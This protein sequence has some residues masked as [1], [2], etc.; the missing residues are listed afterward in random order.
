MSKKMDASRDPAP[1]WADNDEIDLAEY[2]GLL[3]AGKWTVVAST[4]LI[5]LLGV[6][7][8]LLA[9]PIYQTDLLVQVEEESMG[10][11]GGLDEFSGMFGTETASVTEI[12]VLR[13]RHVVGRAVDQL[14]LTTSVSYSSPPFLGWMNPGR[15]LSEAINVGRLDVPQALEGKAYQILA[16]DGG[17][18]F[19]YDGLVVGSGKVGEQLDIS[20]PEGW[21]K[22]FISRLSA[23]AGTKFALVKKPW[24]MAVADLQDH[25][26]IAEKG[27]STGIIRIS[28]EGSDR[29]SLT[30]TLQVVGDIYVRQNVERKSAEA[31]QSLGFLDAQLPQ[32]R[33]QLDAAEISLNNYLKANQTVNLSAETEAILNR[34]VEIEKQES[35]FNLKRTEL[36]QL[37]GK[38]HPSMVVLSEQKGELKKVREELEAQI[39]QLPA[40]QQDILRLSRD[41]EVNGAL[42][43]FLLNKAQELRVIK[44][45]TVGN[46]R[47]LD[48]PVQ[49]YAPIK[50]KK[51]LIVAVAV[52]LGGFLGV[53]IILLRQALRRGIS[54]PNELEQKLGL[55]L[56]CVVPFSDDEA[57]FN[58][59]SNGKHSRV[60]ARENSKELAIEALRG[61]RTSLHFA[62]MESDNNRVVISGASPGVGKSFL[63]V[64]LAYLLA[65]AGKKVLLIDAD[66]RKGHINQYI[67]AKRSPGLSEVISG[68]TAI[69]NAVHT[70]FE[71]QLSVITTGEYPP[72][73]SELL[74][75]DRFPQLLEQLGND[76][77]VVIIDTPP[78]M[79]VADAGIISPLVGATFVAVRAEVNT[80]DEVDAA[81]KRLSQ[82]GNKVS[83]YLFNGLRRSDSKYGYGKYS[84]YQYEYK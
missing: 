58:R 72:N 21:V 14:K 47:I 82:H 48:N 3:W 49:P 78:I 4:M 20:F 29:A 51:S 67:G 26:S 2:I 17:F 22:V 61:M 54:D 53:A 76:Y 52:L 41:V 44:A 25:L 9:T 57:K 73:P 35:A 56:Y 43:T 33:T 84:Y 66:M 46:V 70:P 77:D 71:V 65:E 28:L 55:P 42:Y 36:E 60:L 24:A 40:T 38:Q 50:P 75:S 8:A 31:E 64:N 23:D 37:Y 13:S 11:L 34:V 1:Q 62:L 7:Y 10:G 32:L 6:A 83:G 79:A 45:G 81:T 5:G 74:M 27:K 19:L 59:K 16:H 80:L 30:E 68:Q 63:S 12:E 39:S 15:E 69:E 18:D